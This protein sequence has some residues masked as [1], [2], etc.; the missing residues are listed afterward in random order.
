MP[1]QLLPL[2]P[3]GVVLFPGTPLPLHIFEERYKLMISEAVRDLSEFGVV[4]AGQEGIV[5]AGCTARVEQVLKQYPDGRM[6]ILSMGRRRFQVLELNEELPYLRGRIEYFDDEDGDPPEEQHVERAIRGFYALRHLEQN[7]NLPEPRLND[8]LLSFQLAQAVPDMN[9]R[10]TLLIVRS[11]AERIRQLAD[12]LPSMA[13]KE[14][15]IGKFRELIP[16][17]GRGKYPV[18]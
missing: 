15:E 17:N 4:L 1:E 14:R 9:F 16:T 10:Q 2:F 7:Q 5:N 18:Q 11:E 8:P 13:A 3:L 6:D 12:Y